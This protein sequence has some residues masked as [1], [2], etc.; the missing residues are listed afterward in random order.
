MS[1]EVVTV[2]L[3]VDYGDD[4]ACIED[5]LNSVVAN[6]NTIQIFDILDAREIDD[7]DE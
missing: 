4:E 1:R 7:E 6:S 3:V 5:I 2:A